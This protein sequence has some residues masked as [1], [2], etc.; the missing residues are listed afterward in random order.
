M[1]R[2]FEDVGAVEKTYESPLVEIVKFFGNMLKYVF[3]DCVTSVSKCACAFLTLL[4]IFVVLFSFLLFLRWNNYHIVLGDQSHHTPV[5]HAPQI[6]Y[7]VA[8]T[9]IP[10]FHFN[11]L[12]HAADWNVMQLKKVFVALSLCVKCLGM[13]CVGVLIY[14]FT[15]IHP[16]ILADNR[17]YTFYLWNKGLKH[18]FIQLSMVPIYFYLGKIFWS[19]LLR[20]KGGRVATWLYLLYS[21][22]L[23]PG[24][25]DR[26]P[27][28]YNPHVFCKHS[29]AI[30]ATEGT[31][32]GLVYEM[33]NTRIH[34][35]E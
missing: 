7:F 21:V 29:L 4:P 16:F 27:I 11:L 12:P 26:I 13:I 32:C 9:L 5:F 30:A 23:N 8:F 17:H 33:D 28:F 20:A 1:V 3:R 14:R 10:T 24:T 22:G 34:Y 31:T 6:F 25:F 19:R 2:F 18:R 15:M 35:C